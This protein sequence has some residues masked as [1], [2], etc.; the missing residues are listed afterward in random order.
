MWFTKLTGFKEESPEQVRENIE[1]QGETL[2]SLVNGRSF[3]CGRLEI[4]TLAE[5]REDSPKWEGTARQL[6]VTEIVADV[7][8]L[9]LDPRNQHALFQAASQFNLLEMTSPMV[10]PEMGVDI[11]EEDETQGPACAIACGAVTIYRN[12]FVDVYGDGEL[13]QTAD[14][15][16]DCLELIGEELDNWGGSLWEMRNGYA[17]LHTPGIQDINEQLS[18]LSDEER[19][20]LK[21]K[22]MIGL[23]WDTEVTLIK[24]GG[25]LVNQAYCSALPISYSEVKPADCEAFARL[26]L[27]ATYE[28]TLHA[29]LINLK[30]R[31]CPKVYLTLVGG[32][33]FGNQIDWITD[34]IFVALQRFLHTPLEVS[35]VSYGSSKGEVRKLMNR[36]G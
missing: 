10:P 7:Q 3:Q 16:I 6:K 8:E 34:S 2:T 15:Q 27:E 22:L 35:I 36:L 1:L 32:G 33:V 5:L 28:A 11:Y 25:H 29:A 24:G 31:N 18:A 20:T 21:A 26:I 30:E 19:E 12:Y 9:H 17:L 23:Q 4:P 14:D 13:G